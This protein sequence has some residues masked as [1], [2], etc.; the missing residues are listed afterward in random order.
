MLWRTRVIVSCERGHYRPINQNGWLVKL[1]LLHIAVIVRREVI[2]LDH[3]HKDYQW[4]VQQGPMKTTLIGRTIS[5]YWSNSLY[6]IVI[7][8][9]LDHAWASL[10][11]VVRYAL[12]GPCVLRQLMYILWHCMWCRCN[13]LNAQ[14]F[15]KCSEKRLTKTMAALGLW[16]HEGDWS[17]KRHRPI[18]KRYG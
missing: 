1:A 10:P 15:P 2:V 12:W 9:A 4:S 8:S 17:P 3:S 13:T 18:R 16:C 7:I 5:I 6:C 14:R 11:A